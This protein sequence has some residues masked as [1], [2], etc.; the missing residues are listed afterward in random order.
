MKCEMY[1]PRDLGCSSL[2]GHI[3]VIMD[4]VTQLAD[5]TIR[6]FSLHK[7]RLSSSVS[8]S[9]TCMCLHIGLSTRTLTHTHTHSH[10]HTHTHTHTQ[11]G[12]SKEGRTVKQFHFTSWPDHGVPQYATAMLSM[13]RRV[14]SYHS[15]VSGG[16]MLVHCSAGRSQCSWMFRCLTLIV[17]HQ[18]SAALVPLL[19]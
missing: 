8:H 15:K 17:A 7:V 12:S 9:L 13:L 3:E 1:W 19:S 6:T 11:A 14:R 10:T 18:V 16:P 4:Q 2:H 5:F